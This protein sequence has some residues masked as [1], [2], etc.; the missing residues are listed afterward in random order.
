MEMAFFREG[1]T[2]TA[3]DQSTSL[4]SAQSGSLAIAFSMSASESLSKRAQSVLPFRRSPHFRVTILSFFILPRAACRNDPD[5]I[6]PSYKNDRDQPVLHGPDCDPTLLIL[7]V[8][9]AQNDGTV[10]D[11]DRILEVDPMLLDV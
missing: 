6:C 8:R 4:N 7:A 11:F 3:L 9:S 10:E 5:N 2:T 1:R